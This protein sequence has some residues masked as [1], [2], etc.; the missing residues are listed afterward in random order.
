MNSSSGASS[1]ATD[2]DVTV[3][4]ADRSSNADS[5]TSSLAPAPLSPDH[6]REIIKHCSHGPIASSGPAAPPLLD[7]PVL[8]DGGGLS[9][10]DK[11]A[12]VHEDVEFLPFSTDFD[13][14]MAQSCLTT[15]FLALDAA[16]A[17]TAACPRIS[18]RVVALVHSTL[19]TV[20]THACTTGAGAE[21]GVA[22][23]AKEES[24]TV[25]P[26]VPALV[27][28]SLWMEPAHQSLAPGMDAPGLSKREHGGDGGDR[29]VLKMG[30]AGDN[31]S[32]SRDG[33][34]H[35]FVKAEKVDAQSSDIKSKLKSFVR[36][37]CA[38]VEK[39]LG[40]EGLAV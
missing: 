26:S 3:I 22:S 4:D 11:E 6:A 13:L 12:T 20:L 5:S 36:S 9:G 38:S 34:V 14:S 1:N 37:V 32:A 40:I 30:G 21:A 10:L 18:D 17:V 16:A 7:V 24:G 25:V 31:A 19:A 27:P 8:I 33:D 15:G 39:K 35:D 29:A 28:S 2:G 23:A